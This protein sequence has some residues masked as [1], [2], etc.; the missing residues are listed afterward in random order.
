MWKPFDKIS[1]DFSNAAIY[2]QKRAANQRKME[3]VSQGLLPVPKTKP[4]ADELLT[5]NGLEIGHASIQVITREIML[6][7]CLRY[8]FN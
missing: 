5:V 8:T 1:L 6:L 7:P 4:I 3:L 2:S